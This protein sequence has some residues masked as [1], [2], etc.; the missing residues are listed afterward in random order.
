VHVV[1]APAGT[2]PN[3][4]TDKTQSDADGGFSFTLVSGPGLYELLP[5]HGPFCIE[6]AKDTYGQEAWLKEGDN[7]PL[8]L[9]YPEAFRVPMRVVDE[10]GTPVAGAAIKVVRRGPDVTYVSNVVG[11]TNEAGRYVFEEGIPGIEHLFWIACAGYANLESHRA[12][13]GAIVGAPGETLEEATFVLYHGAGAEGVVLLEDGTPAAGLPFHVKVFADG[14][15]AMSCNI[16]TDGEGRFAV[17]DEL[18]GVRCEIEIRLSPDFA[19]TTGRIAYDGDPSRIIDLGVLRLA[20]P[21]DG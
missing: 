3:D 13:A 9:V 15:G 8:T 17:L 21:E 4:R 6:L 14:G 1:I 10:T 2:A 11:E 20:K 16:T 18:P 5:S 19:L 12:D 7:E